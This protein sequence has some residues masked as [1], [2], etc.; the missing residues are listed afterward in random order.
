VTPKAAPPKAAAPP[1]PKPAPAPPPAPP[2]PAPVVDRDL[3]A[4]EITLEPE[5]ELALAPEPVLDL[6]QDAAPEPGLEFSL[7]EPGPPPPETPQPLEAPF[8]FEA[9][10]VPVSDELQLAPVEPEPV[11]EP[12]PPVAE[13]DLFAEAVQ[14]IEVLPEPVATVVPEPEVI[15]QPQDEMSESLFADELLSLVEGAFK[16]QPAEE[17]TASSAPSADGA[18][19]GGG[20][21][22]VVSPLFKDFSVDELVAVIQGLN[23]LTYQPGEIIIM[24]GDPGQSLYMLTSGTVRAMKRNAQGR[25]ATVGELTE[26]AFFGELSILSGKPRSATVV[27]ATYCELLELDRATLDGIVKTHPRV[28]EILKEFATARQKR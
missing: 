21:Q 9:E 3:F 25:Q 20:N 8:A 27:A 24:E 15:P 2:P 12:V 7:T 23:L 16:D 13:V 6:P 26:G 11:V 22:I 28:L 19:T 4:G 18:P 14:A 17:A 10:A 1:A 5:P